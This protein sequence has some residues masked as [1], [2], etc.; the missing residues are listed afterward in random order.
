M[1]QAT[2]TKRI[3][4]P[5]NPKSLGSQDI[6]TLLQVVRSIGPV[7]DLT[8]LIDRVGRD[9]A[10]AFDADSAVL[11][12]HAPEKQR[13]WSLVRQRLGSWP[14]RVS[15]GENEGLCGHV[16][17]CRKPML[18]D[19][20]SHNAQFSQECP[21]LGP[22]PQSVMA[23]PVWYRPGHCAGV[24]QV[25]HRHC[26]VFDASA[27]ALLT[28]IAEPVA[29]AVENAQRHGAEQKQF[30]TAVCALT[31][32]LDA[33]DAV[34]AYHSMNVANY[35]MGIGVI[36][37]L[38]A[39]NLEWLR[40]AG[41]LH[42]VGTIGTPDRV[43]SKAGWLEKE[44]Y[45]V[46]KKHASYT[47]RI[48]QQIAF[49]PRYHDMAYLASAHHEK[50]DGSGYPDGLAGNLVPLKPRILCVADMFHALTQPR[51]HRPGMPLNIAISVLDDHVPD[52][53]DARCVA[54]LK[55][56]LGIGVPP[57]PAA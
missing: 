2:T 41:L 9:L 28:T 52:Q 50:L 55:A 42:N 45:D 22:P 46:V 48:L 38:D 21:P 56:F 26:G 39:R 32:A 36:L 14:R 29:V 30:D 16:F 31:N 35:A 25:N 3:R 43:L 49:A 24:L 54:A 1:I 4:E 53:I 5:I 47:R 34:T 13:L 20:L 18:L 6:E 57:K 19:D 40:V 12:L 8:T 10:A 15:I 44:E 27:L 23:V 51:P 17:Q 33:R 7:L 37:G 11:Y